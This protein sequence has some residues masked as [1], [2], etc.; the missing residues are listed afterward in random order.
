MGQRL[1]SYKKGSFVLL[2]I[3]QTEVPRVRACMHTEIINSEKV[4]NH[5]N[6]QG[7]GIDEEVVFLG[8]F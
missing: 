7:N 4:K 1:T 2:Q 6:T 3:N 5:D 8:F